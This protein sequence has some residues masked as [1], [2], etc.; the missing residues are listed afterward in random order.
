MQDLPTPISRLTSTECGRQIG[1][2]AQVIRAPTCSEVLD[3]NRSWSP[4]KRVGPS[5]FWCLMGQAEAP[6]G[7]VV[8]VSMD[9]VVIVLV[10]CAVV[11]LWAIALAALVSA[12]R[13]PGYAWK[14]ARRSKAGTITG[15]LLTGGFGGLLYWFRIRPVVADAA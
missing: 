10:V 9:A 11:A 14:V 2:T 15:I 4:V 12:A 1:T 3:S 13:L 6:I 7:S 5:T 8:L